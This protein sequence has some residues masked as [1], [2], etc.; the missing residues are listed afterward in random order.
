MGVA[1][2][3]PCNPSRDSSATRCRTMRPETTR[4]TCMNRRRFLVG[5]NGVSAFVSENDG[6]IVGN[7]DGLV[8]AEP[9]GGV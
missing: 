1:V 4:D 7:G 6:V 2:A 8:E 3:F 9:E 5:A